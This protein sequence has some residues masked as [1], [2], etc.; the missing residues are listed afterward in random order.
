MNPSPNSD[1]RFKGSVPA[2]YDR[3]LGPLVFEPF[4]ADLATRVAKIKPR[5]VLE[6]AAGTGIVS[7]RLLEVLPPSSRLTATDLNAPMLEIARQKIGTDSR[8][9]FRQADAL[10]L[11]FSDGE[12]DTVVCQFGLMFFPDK[13]KGLREFHRVLTAGGGLLINL[14]DTI[15]ANPH[16]KIAHTALADTFETDPPAFYLVPFGFHDVT[17]IRKVVTEA[18]FTEVEIETIELTGESPSA[19]DAAIGLLRGNPCIDVVMERGPERA[20]D[21]ERLMAKRLAERYGDK[22]LR[23]PMRAHVVSAIADPAN[24]RGA[25]Q[26]S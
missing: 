3:Y 10:D 20:G 26:N 17:E 8:V 13:L 14:W 12:F 16:G 11:P 22:P 2:I 7:R 21:I 18:G 6:V 23:L 15:E 1:T 19:A 5:N 24:S 25:R 9:A 4:A